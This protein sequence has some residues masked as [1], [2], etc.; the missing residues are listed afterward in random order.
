MARTNTALIN[1]AIS[2]FWPASSATEVFDRLPSTT[3]PPTSPAAPFAMPCAMSSW[4]VSMLVAVLARHATRRSERLRVAD[5]DDRQRADQQR[6]RVAPADPGQS[7]REQAGRDVA[8]DRNA[9]VGEVERLDRDDRERHHDQRPRQLRKD[10]AHHQQQRERRR[11]DSERRAARV[12]DRLDRSPELLHVRAV[13]PGY[14]EQLV[15]LVDDD[16]DRR[17]RGRS[18]TSPPSTGTS[19]SS[20]SAAG[21]A[22]GRRSAVASASAAA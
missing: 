12:R 10:V 17:T 13:D 8:R 21:R 22:R 20:P 6:P 16:A 18:P 11:T 2:V 3:N 5:E 15:R 19:R 7:D 1:D 14:A 9:V 4:F